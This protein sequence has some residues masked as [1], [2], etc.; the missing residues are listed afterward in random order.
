MSSRLFS[1]LLLQS[2]LA[3][4]VQ[5]TIYITKPFPGSSC[6]GGKPCTVEWLD[7]GVVPL[8]SDI[9]ACHVALYNG[10]QVLIQQI[11]PVVVSAQH[12]LDF[13]PDPKAGPNS[14]E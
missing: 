3:W 12:A 1:V 4:L 2:A 10:N 14:S 8:L 11:S 5:G 7:D 9:D 13:T 6:S